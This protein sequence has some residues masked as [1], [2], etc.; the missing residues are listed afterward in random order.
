MQCLGKSRRGIVCAVA[1]ALVV[2]PAVALAGEQSVVVL[3]NG[4]VLH[5][6][7]AIRGERYEVTTSHSVVEVPAAQVLLVADSMLD[8]YQRQRQQL[9]RDTSEAH[10]GLAEWC[11]RYDLLQPAAQELADARRL[12]PRDPRVALLERRLAVSR[13]AKTQAEEHAASKARED[14]SA[15]DELRKLESQVADLPPG[16]VEKFTRKVQPLLVNSCTTSGCHHP[17]GEQSFQLDRA[18]LHGLS[19]RRSTLRNLVATL[20]LVNR[21][22]PQQ[23]DL[24]TI[25][26][27]THGG[28][29]RPLFG[30]RQEAQLVQLADWIGKVTETGVAAEPPIADAQPAPV[31]AAAP[32]N[33][34]ERP[35]RFIDDQVIPASVGEMESLVSRQ[36][37]RF[38]AELKPWAP[39]D[40]FDPEIFNRQTHDAAARQN[41]PSE[42]LPATR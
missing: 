18:V 27:R 19:N 42:Q 16:V 35:P 12:D 24:L 33:L 2:C 30:P 10:L 39:R 4:G 37:N 25:P 32:V 8:A 28:M 6:K 11:L 3:G 38:G 7:V 13:G 40:E 5:G 29:Q 15:K 23:S 1:L 22:A 34:R 41:P 31:H 17:A 14:I 20:E 9:P 26:R 21:D 36:P